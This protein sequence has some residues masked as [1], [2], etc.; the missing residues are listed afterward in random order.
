[1]DVLEK[2]LIDGFWP[3]F[4]L[5][6][7]H[8]L[9]YAQFD[10][11]SYPMVCFCDIPL[12]RISEHVDFYG[13]FGLGM[14]KT[15]AEKN[16]LNPVLYVSRTSQAAVAFSTLNHHANQISP[17]EKQNDAKKT[18]RYL[19]AFTKPTEGEMVVDGKPVKKCFYQES[20]WRYVPEN[21]NP[22][23]LLRVNHEISTKLEKANTYTLNNCLLKFSPQDIKYIFVKSDSD[24]PRIM[25]FIQ[26][27]MDN[28]PA[29]DLKILMSR[30]VSLESLSQDI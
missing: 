24:I 1:M 28:H 23:Y 27:N 6:D 2:V 9:G 13:N 5:E 25:N 10:Y 20:E 11:V 21:S 14:T 17:E 30:V 4:C 29:A 18:I 26:N 12:S 15:W 16:G 8:W 19:Y 7:V 22:S 3:R